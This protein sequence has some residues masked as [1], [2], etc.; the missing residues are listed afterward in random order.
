MDF[1]TYARRHRRFNSPIEPS[2]LELLAAHLLRGEP[3]KIL[4]L[5]CGTGQWLLELLTCAPSAQGLGVDLDTFGIEEAVRRTK[6]AGLEDRVDWRV[7]DAS[8]ASDVADAV[9]CVGSSHAFGGLLPT[10]EALHAL[11]T[12]GGRALIGESL[13]M[14]QPGQ[15]Y[16]DLVGEDEGLLDH[17]GNVRAIEQAGFDVVFASTASLREWDVFEWG[18]YR[19]ALEY[20]RSHP[21][22]AEAAAR[23][24]RQR[25]WRDGY[26]SMGRGV[27]G[28]GYYVVRAV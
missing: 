17:A 3:E 27:R 4:D 8:V 9:V 24:E 13:W 2:H 28:F 18:F 16:L 19:V 25:R 21:E 26:L 23:L 1:P 14:A 5:G 10:L 22:D 20:A 11:L 15:A 6:L 7:Q 12:P